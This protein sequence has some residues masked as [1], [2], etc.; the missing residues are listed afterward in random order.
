MTELTK[1]IPMNSIS[2]K[3]PELKTANE[4]R[5][6]IHTALVTDRPRIST[7]ILEIDKMLHGGL[8]NE[9]YI[10]GADTSTGKSAFMQSIAESIS[11]AGTANVLYFA[12]EMS[13]LELI[14]RGISKV[15]FEMS[16][17]D[18]D[19]KGTKFSDI[20][21]WKYDSVCNIFTKISPEEYKVAEEE[22]FEGY[23]QNIVFI[24]GGVAGGNVSN[25]AQIAI[26]YKQQHPEKPV[27]VF[28]DYLQIVRADPDDRSQ[29]DRK[30]KMDIAVLT[31]KT[32]ASQVGMPVFV[33]S[34]LS[35]AGYQDR[36]K[37]SSFKESGD[38]EYTG[39]VLLGLNWCGVSNQ[40][41]ED[42][43][44][45]EK[46]KCEARGYRIMALDLLKN[47]NAARD[48]SAT[49]YYY[50]AYNYYTDVKP[51]EAI[52]RKPTVLRL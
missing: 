11:K 10:L 14:A 36:V 23:G 12:F 27:V 28:V 25:I 17:R 29:A 26:N 45:E 32:L 1:Q 18:P 51:E 40:K 47:R 22:Y 5:D 15:S 13:T 42:E 4:M 48:Q 30:T 21:H 46:N 44:K 20:L 34:S 37:N 6:N 2:T 9:L 41:N 16:M 7:G 38:L 8:V 50:P 3:V 19:V 31:L 43:V 49:L 52:V 24:E 35:R 39:G 33:A